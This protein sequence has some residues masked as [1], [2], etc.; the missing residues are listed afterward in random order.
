[1]GNET[2][3]LA[4]ILLIIKKNINIGFKTNNKLNNLISKTLESTINSKKD[5]YIN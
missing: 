2:S 4:K 5:A 1:M 3:K